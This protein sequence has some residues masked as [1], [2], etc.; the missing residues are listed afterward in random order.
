[1]QEYE[2]E[3]RQQKKKQTSI[4]M[5]AV[6]SEALLFPIQF[7]T[8]LC[9]IFKLF[10]KKDVKPTGEHGKYEMLFCREFLPTILQ[11]IQRA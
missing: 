9:Y 5:A 8:C 10:L 1:M 4:K 3:R 6:S 11:K 2:E 7:K